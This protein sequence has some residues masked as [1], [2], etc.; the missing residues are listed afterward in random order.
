MGE[1]AGK[2]FRERGQGS[3]VQNWGHYPWGGPN[4]IP[5][6]SGRHC[7][8][9]QPERLCARFP[10]TQCSQGFSCLQAPRTA[11][12]MFTRSRA[13]RPK[14]RAPLPGR[15]VDATLGTQATVFLPH[16]HGSHP[17]A[18]I[19]SPG[20]PKPHRTPGVSTN[21]WAHTPRSS[22]TFT[23]TPSLCVYQEPPP[24]HSPGAASLPYT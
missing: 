3:G 16:Y 7:S 18:H 17:P 8:H 10:S 9:T 2:Q 13:P 11:G 1:G 12:Q 22:L 6:S 21:T 24:S 19:H 5:G 15:E 20:S 14:P 23:R 4:S